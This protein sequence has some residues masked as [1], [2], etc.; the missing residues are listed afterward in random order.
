MSREAFTLPD[1]KMVPLFHQE[2]KSMGFVIV[3]PS[4]EETFADVWPCS[5]WLWSPDSGATTDKY[6]RNGELFVFEK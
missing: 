6:L 1:V 2:I 3:C 5:G 4:A